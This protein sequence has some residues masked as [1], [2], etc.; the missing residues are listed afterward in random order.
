MAPANSA[1]ERPVSSAPFSTG[2]ER[3]L[4]L[5]SI[6]QLGILPGI[7]GN[8]CKHRD[9][10]VPTTMEE[11]EAL[12]RVGRCSKREGKYK[13]LVRSASTGLPNLVVDPKE[14][15]LL[16]CEYKEPLKGPCASVL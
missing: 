5:F 9:E 16:F 13:D 6:P 10:N 12:Q 14:D 11:R 15:V 3:V 8:G 2:P 7:I 1:D 4:Q